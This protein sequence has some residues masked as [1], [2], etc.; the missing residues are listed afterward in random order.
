M[1]S[2]LLGKISAEEFCAQLHALNPTLNPQKSALI[3]FLSKA[4]PS[5][6]QELNSDAV[7]DE[8]NSLKIALNFEKEC[9]PMPCTSVEEHKSKNVQ[10][11]K[12]TITSESVPITVPYISNFH[13][14]F[15]ISDVYFNYFQFPLFQKFFKRI[16]N[17]E[18]T[19][20]SRI[21]RRK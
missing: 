18:R 12:A 10:R 16:R 2:I 9:F 7:S 21:R 4:L 13:H 20:F 17:M 11:T 8:L 3:T 5:L 15:P 1:K 14:I 6:R 19:V